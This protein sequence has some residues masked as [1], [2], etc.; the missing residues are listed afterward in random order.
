MREE[1]DAWA[2]KGALGVGRQGQQGAAG[3]KY[4]LCK[5]FAQGFAQGQC[6]VLFYGADG[7]RRWRQEGAACGRSRR[8]GGKTTA[9]HAEKKIVERGGKNL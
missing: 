6:P 8:A 2:E 1:T 3:T 7:G 9:G 5:K 4:T